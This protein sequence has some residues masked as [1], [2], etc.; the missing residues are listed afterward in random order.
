[1]DDVFCPVLYYLYV[2]EYDEIICLIEK[3]NEDGGGEEIYSK[4]LK[5][6][7]KG[8]PTHNASSCSTSRLSEMVTCSGW[9]SL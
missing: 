4:R 9:Y 1:M 7:V 8:S 6:N 5:L 2:T 3:K